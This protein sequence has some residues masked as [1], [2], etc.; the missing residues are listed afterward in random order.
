M[1]VTYD[2]RVA[3]CCSDWGAMH[4][5]GYISNEC[6]KDEDGDKKLVIDRINNNK[7][8]F[9]LMKNVKLP[10]KFNNPSKNVQTLSEIWTGSEV[11]RVRRFHGEGKLHKVTI[12]KDCTFKDT[13]NWIGE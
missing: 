5:I 3:M 11:E 4:P 12:C 8:G 7:K 1:M 6:F 9:E 2:G 13:Y 10:P